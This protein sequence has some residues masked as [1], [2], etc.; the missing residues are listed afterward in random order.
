VT[1]SG[2]TASV[3]VVCTGC[4]LV[5]DDILLQPSFAGLAAEPRF[6]RACHAGQVWL[7]AA[8]LASHQGPRSIVDGQ[9]KTTASALEIAADRLVRARRVLVTGFGDATLETVMAT[10]DVAEWLSAAVDGGGIEAAA[11]AGSAVGRVGRVT[12][13]FEELRDRADC[14]L[15]W[16]VDPAL[17]HPR[18]AERFLTATVR[19]RPRRVIAVGPE[20]RATDIA[21]RC[22]HVALGSHEAAEAA[23]MLEMLLRERSEGHAG[24][25]ASRCPPPWRQRAESLAGLAAACG[26]ADCVAFVS[27]DPSTDAASAD[28]TGI[29]RIVLSRCVAWLAHRRPAFEVPLSAGSASGNGHTTSSAAVCGW[30]YGGPA[31]IA[32]ASRDAA[33]L[34]PAEAD[35]VRLIERHEVDGLLVIGRLPDRLRPILYQS[36]AMLVQLGDEPLDVSGPS[37]WI[38]AASPSLTAR[39]HILRDDG[40][41]VRTHSL[42]TSKR[43]SL[44]AL[45]RQLLERLHDQEGRRSARRPQGEVRA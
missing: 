4:P 43:S 26:Q 31:A 27:G 11:V 18:F 35:A 16:F 28:T 29:S 30:R 25:I 9:E 38:A 33:V 13:D 14:V 19:G 20:P 24:V 44:D 40:H 23:A 2:A 42:V 37:V 8:W 10:T 6:E 21:S 1:A 39:G 45:L 22:E 15:L 5:C 36:S 3:E 12:A 34:R 41:I 7:Q 17:S 32:A